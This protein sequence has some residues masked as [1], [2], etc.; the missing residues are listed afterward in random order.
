MSRRFRFRLVDVFTDRALQG[1]P[2]AVFPEAEGM[3]E[4]EMQSLGRE[5][6]LSDTAFVLPASAERAGLRADFRVRIFTPTQELAFAGHSAMGAAWVLADDGRF[7]QSGS[8]V[9]VRE[10]L[11]VGVYPMTV[12]VTGRGA[13]RR[14]REVTMTQ[15]EVELIDRVGSD[16]MDE[17]SAS[18]EVR[19]RDLRWPLNGESAGRLRMPAVISCGLP[20]L[21]VPFARLDLLADVEGER[22]ADLA[23][24]AETYGSDTMALIAPGNSGAVPD[25]D[26]HAR[27]LVDPRSGIIEDPATGSAAGPIAI[28]L[29]LLARQR[30]ATRR[31]VI[32]Q[33]VEIGRPSRL[34]AEVDF[35][36]EG[37]PVE[38]RVTGEVVPVAE[39]W[40]TLP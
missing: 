38:A 14:V 34:V 21:V 5:M 22:A 11:A 1:N 40:V 15:A 20:I 35:S 23:R 17:L 3:T 27:I 25:A 16:E 30:G 26:V 31:V 39:G 7:P 37:R 24:F 10:E 8:E 33:G 2:L 32:E 13:T 12:R 28:F 36:V 9:Q 29:G 6:N 19:G 4:A 18:L